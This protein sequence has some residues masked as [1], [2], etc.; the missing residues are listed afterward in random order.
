VA[1]LRMVEMT[2][3]PGHVN[4]NNKKENNIIQQQKHPNYTTAILKIDEN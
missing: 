2:A 3:E 4:T 1:G